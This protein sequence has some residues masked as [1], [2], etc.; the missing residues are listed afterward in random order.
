MNLTG[1]WPSWLM[2]D[3]SC[4]SPPWMQVQLDGKWM[5]NKWCEHGT[6]SLAGELVTRMHM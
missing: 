1:G 6:E 2:H 4:G 5:E 3:G